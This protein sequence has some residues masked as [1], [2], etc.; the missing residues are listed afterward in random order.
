M[1]P[2]L[3]IAH[4]AAHPEA[5]PT[6]RA[7][8]EAAWPSYYGPGGPG[9]AERDLAAYANLGTL[10]VGIVAFRARQLC[11]VAALKSETIPSHAH[12]GPWAGAGLVA[13][14]FRGQGIGARLL[15][16]LENEA[17]AL[18]FAHIY[19]A[20]STAARLLERNAWCF[21]DSVERDGEVVRV[22]EKRSRT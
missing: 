2:Q 8:F 11:A 5:L 22:Y 18:G 21:I 16:R 17:A 4:L 10:P 14:A 1:P 12:L 19:C 9:N 3:S 20:T 6:L 7:W 13:P 15:A